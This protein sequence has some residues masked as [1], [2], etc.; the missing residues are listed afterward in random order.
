MKISEE[1]G[2]M[3]FGNTELEEQRSEARLNS[4]RITFD[5]FHLKMKNKNRVYCSKGKHLGRAKDGTA[6]IIS[7]LKGVSLGVCKSCEFFDGGE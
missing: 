1:T 7:I 3:L 2:D 4:G 6:D 5:C